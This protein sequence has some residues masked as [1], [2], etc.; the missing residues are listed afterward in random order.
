ML[1]LTATSERRS[2]ARGGAALA[3]KEE[4]VPQ[5]PARCRSCLYCPERWLTSAC[6][7]GYTYERISRTSRSTT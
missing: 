2:V 3:C 1:S 5:S 7:R 6:E 4:S